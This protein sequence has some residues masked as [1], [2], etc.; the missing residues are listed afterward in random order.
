MEGLCWLSYTR[1]LPLDIYGRS[2]TLHPIRHLVGLKPD[3]YNWV[4]PTQTYTVGYAAT[5]EAPA[6]RGHAPPRIVTT[7]RGEG[8]GPAKALRRCNRV[9]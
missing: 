5:C 9:A 7:R 6:T 4:W 2:N 1:P 8:V 3:L